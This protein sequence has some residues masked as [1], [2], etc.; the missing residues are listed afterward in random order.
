MTSNHALYKEL[1]SQLKTMISS[2]ANNNPAPEMGI[3]CNISED[4]NFVDVRMNGGVLKGLQ[5]WG[6]EPKLNDPCILI[7]LSGNYDNI[8]AL[9]NIYKG[10]TPCLNKIRN[11]NFKQY[12]NNKFTGWT[13]GEYSDINYWFGE[14]T[15][16]IKPNQYIQSEYANI[17]DLKDKTEL[18]NTILTLLYYYLGEIQIEILDIKTGKA[19]VLAPENLN[20][21]QE[22][23][24][25]VNSWYYAR[26][27]F[28]IHDYTH[29]AVRITNLS[30]TEYAYIDGVRLW[31]QDFKGW[32]PSDKD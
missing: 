3:I 26:T 7:F 13:G 29:V 32:Y 30:S 8:I 21:T 27:N 10:K 14:H 19:I 12:V 23:L 31:S 15:I 28:L 18:E 16:K 4:E 6:G 1:D 9:C 22:V 2:V 5:R 25:E 11:G 20:I 24:D 17:S